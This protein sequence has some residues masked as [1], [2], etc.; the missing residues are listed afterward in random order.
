MTSSVDKNVGGILDGI[1]D[2]DVDK[3]AGK[4]SWRELVIIVDIVVDACIVE[5]ST[6]NI[7]TSVEDSKYPKR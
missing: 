6:S 4:S 3:I 5:S 7:D 1:M 2:G